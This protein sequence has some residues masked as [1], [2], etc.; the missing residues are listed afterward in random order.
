M[1]AVSEKLNLNGVDHTARPTWKLRETVRFYRDI[2]GLPLVH[3]VTAKGWGRADE[4]HADFLH[5][6][7]DS[8][9]ESLIAFFYYI[10]TEQPAELKVP[11]GYMAM[12]NHTAW[13]V[14]GEKELLAWQQRLQGAGVKVSQFITHEIIESIYFRDPN[15][16]PLEITRAL[17]DV[18]E[19]DA[20]D[21][22]LTIEAAMSLEGKDGWT[23]IEQFWRTKGALVRERQEA[24][25][26]HSGAAQ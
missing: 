1:A 22:E 14:S 21:A 3:A 9:N 17:R 13:R 5:F 11:R 23:S 20:V 8:G 26:A 6:F 12:A 24:A 4:E 10:G 25:L 2:M 15:G 7:F 16:Y 19:I 18:E